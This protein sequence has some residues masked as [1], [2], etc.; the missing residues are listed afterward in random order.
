MTGG[1][2]TPS[3]FPGAWRSG[4]FFRLVSRAQRQTDR[5]YSFLSVLATF[6]NCFRCHVHLF[7]GMV[8]VVVVVVVDVEPFG[9]FESLG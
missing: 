2:P 4:S 1:R 7:C 6:L 8:V 5:N 3:T 9:S